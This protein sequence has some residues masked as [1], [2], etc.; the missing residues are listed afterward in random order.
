MYGLNVFIPE[1]MSLPSVCKPSNLLLVLIICCVL[2]FFYLSCSYS[3][4][5]GTVRN[6]IF[7]TRHP[8]LS[9]DPTVHIDLL[10]SLLNQA[11]TNLNEQ[12]SQNF[13]ESSPTNNDGNEAR[14]STITEVEETEFSTTTPDVFLADRKQQ[15]L[16]I[17][18]TWRSGS[19]TFANI[20]S[21]QQDAYLHYEPL[22]GHYTASL[23]D[24]GVT[25]FVTNITNTL[26]SC[27]YENLDMEYLR[28]M[29]FKRVYLKENNKL[30]D[31]CKKSRRRTNNPC[32]N[33]TFMS[34]QCRKYPIQIVKYVRIS[35]AQ[36][37]HYLSYSNVKIIWLVRDPRAVWYSRQENKLVNFWCLPGLCGDLERL[38]Q[39][40]RIN[41]EVSEQLK[42]SHP[43]SFLKVKFEDIQKDP[44][45]ETERITNFLQTNNPDE[46]RDKIKLLDTRTNFTTKKDWRDNLSDELRL[47]VERA[48]G[49]AMY[50]LGYL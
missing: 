38:C 48:C 34:E 47:E 36:V 1:R 20:L 10:E 2:V 18:S 33:Q 29:F 25:D 4:S 49:D 44:Y 35:L 21:S 6:D 41:W 26:L 43:D 19:T 24:P 17:V 5:P 27:D 9:C 14:P 30:P 23:T 45:G 46:I 42:V 15:N 40:Y 28:G 12:E 8:E 32:L 13:S 39:S 16:L 22:D 31:S 50:K 11:E 3:A 37:S 7:K